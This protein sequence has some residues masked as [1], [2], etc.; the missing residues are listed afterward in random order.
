[1]T[2]IGFT[3][4]AT[5]VGIAQQNFKM[6]NN[7]G[8][9]SK[10]AV[11]ASKGEPMYQKE[12]DVDED[13]IITFKEFMDY[14]DEQGISYKE[15]MLM[16][17]NRMTYQLN[18]KAEESSEKVQN[19]AKKVGFDFENVDGAI[20][21][22]KEELKEVIDVYNT[23]NMDKIKDE[24]GD[25]LFSCVNVARILNIDEESALNATIDK[26]VK[27]FAYIEAKTQEK[28]SNLSDIS[29]EEM[30]KLWDESKN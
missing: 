10:N 22:V 30:N 1:M 20:E 16:L 18:K 5:G 9:N 11:Y 21:K 12:M 13:G 6:S 3:S 25:L 17:N 7:V 19:E 26:F 23:K 15:R 4:T 14:C 29:L 24:I 27:R 28:E 8:T 2:G